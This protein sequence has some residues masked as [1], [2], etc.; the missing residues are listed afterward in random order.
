MSF[1]HFA[2]PYEDDAQFFGTALPFLAEGAARGDTMFAVT[3]P[4]KR[5]LLAAELGDAVQ[6]L[7]QAVFYEH[8]MRIIAK[9]LGQWEEGAAEG[10]GLRIL[11]EPHWAEWG[12]LEIL[13]W[14]RLEALVNLVFA[15]TDASFMCPY[16]LENLPLEILEAARRTHPVSAHG[17][18][19]REN[20]GYLEPET[21]SAMCDRI[22]LAPAPESSTAMPVFSPDMRDLRA[23]VA[24]HAR[25]YGLSGGSLHQL[26]VAVTEVA[27]NALRHGTPPIVLR[28]WPDGDELVCE[29]ADEGHWEPE[30]SAGPGLVPP[31]PAKTGENPRL[32]L[33]AVRMLCDIVQV[34]TGPTGTRIRIRTPLCA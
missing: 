7:D 19:R 15:G 3:S 16:D 6:M 18:F 9:V 20:P 13:E 12:R 25:Q 26:L 14:Q 29:V 30:E 22:P 27:T 34:R 11:G 32:G 17:R 2:L 8:P 10:R 24:V 21:F 4:R 23:L 5:E 1:G 28:L 33:W 31:N